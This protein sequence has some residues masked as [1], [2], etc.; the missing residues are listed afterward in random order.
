MAFTVV[1]DFQT[2]LNACVSVLEWK[3]STSANVWKRN[4]FLGS[5]AFFEKSLSDFRNVDFPALAIFYPWLAHE[6]S[7]IFLSDLS[8]LAI[9][10][11]INLRK[12]FLFSAPSVTNFA[13]TQC[14]YFQ[15]YIYI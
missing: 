11:K 5:L 4:H 7:I 1:D 6:K 13:N 8:A 9:I 2:A 14:L 10:E 15:P 12:R 3:T